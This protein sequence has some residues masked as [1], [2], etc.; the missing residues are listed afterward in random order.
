M[1]LNQVMIFFQ[2]IIQKLTIH[3]IIVF[4]DEEFDKY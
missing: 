4:N 1:N 3:E 2:I